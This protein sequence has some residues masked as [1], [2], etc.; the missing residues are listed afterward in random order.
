MSSKWRTVRC[1]VE[2][3]TPDETLSE[4]DFAAQVQNWVDHGQNVTSRMRDSRIW[5]KG[6]NSVV[7][8]MDKARPRRLQAV[9]R[10]LDKLATRLRKL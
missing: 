2:Y 6:F 5:A 1:V 4:R 10:A 9:S 7:A 3:R 8:R